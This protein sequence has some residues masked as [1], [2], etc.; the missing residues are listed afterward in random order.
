MSSAE[1]RRHPRLPVCVP[2][3]IDWGSETLR[4]EV[5]DVSLGGMFLQTEDPLW[6]NAR[7]AARIRARQTIPVDCIVR[8]VVPGRG[9]GVEFEGINEGTRRLLQALLETSDGK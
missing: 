1:R 7:F 9:M 2:V 5:S 4:A 3:E 6:V 8:R